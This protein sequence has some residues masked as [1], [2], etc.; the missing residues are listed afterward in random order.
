MPDP[1]FAAP[2]FDVVEV[3]L[4]IAVDELFEYAVPT[5]LARDAQPGRRALVPLGSRRV[6]GLIVSR[7]TLAPSAERARPL[8]PVARVLD[9][10]AVLSNALI[11]IL[12]EAAR[13]FL[14]PVGVALC[15]ALP[16]GSPRGS[17]RAWAP[18]A[19]GRQAL[20]RGA[21]RGA[22]ASLLAAL[23]Q[24]P[25]RDASIQRR[26][27]SWPPALRALARDGLVQAEALPPNVRPVEVR[28]IAVAPGVDAD[29]ARAGPLA[30][31]PRQAALLAR[32][33][34]AGEV[35]AASLNREFPGAAGLL[36]A[37]L[38]RALVVEGQRAPA[39]PGVALAGDARAAALTPEQRTALDAV[40]AAVRS[41]APERFLLHGVTGSGKTEVYLRAIAV[42]LAA[43]RQAL[44][45]VPEITLTH[46]IVARLRARFGDR[47]AILHSGLRQ[48]E[49][50]AQWQRL[51]RGATP[52]AVGARSALFAPLDDLGLI[53]V[54]EEHDPAYKSEEG[55][56]Y[57]AR[58][59]AAR[60]AARSPCPLLLGSATPSLETRFAA[61]RAEIERLVLPRRVTGR[62]LPAVEIVDLARE[63]AARTPG[64]KLILSQP[65]RRALAAALAESGQAILLLNRR[66]FSTRVFC[67]ECGHAERCEHCDVSLVFHA[68]ENRLRCHYCG[69][70]AAPPDACSGCGAPDTA[71]LGV[72][73]ERL[74]EEVRTAFPEARIARLDRDT[75]RRRGAAEAVLA[76]LASGALDIVV[77][78][79]MLAKGHD[80]P[81]VRLVGVVAADLGLHLPDFRAA[82]RTFQLLTQVAGRAGRGKLPGR[83][84]VQTFAPDH[85][86]I[87]PVRS[88]AYETF[89]AEE[90]RHRASL[91]YPP[92][93]SLLRVVV[94]SEDRATAEAEAARLAE[95]ARS[96]GAGVDVLAA[97]APIARL[98]D[99]FRFQILARSSDRKQLL[100]SGRRIL[101]ASAR[102]PRDVRASVDVD[103]ISML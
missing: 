81:G 95:A 84:I 80:F 86:A 46:Q 15:A 57:C 39:S 78:T 54:D 69:L 83:V 14:C 59:L 100:E 41:R 65:L 56:R 98:R 76:G 17:V 92:F 24:R 8:R 90:L 4:P 71:L 75:A 87:R 49:R 23:S 3:A 73:T 29:V 60:R 62:P 28:T 74:E 96:E 58:D 45:L 51:R 26:D 50:R 11:E 21:L 42:A 33:R 43:G 37:L 99:R 47:V 63:R 22:A 1:L 35:E 27:P 13:D 82:E 89:Y 5:S 31:A 94:S 64:R 16:A 25:L 34:D 48:G 44:V 102:L 101:D 61:D 19:K 30:H 32:L 20:A 38:R 70:A 52:I 91:L 6:T 40:A 9:A 2:Q 7:R 67:F 103:P 36:R 10:E 79:Q 97:P 93:G 85:Y 77:G 68:T 12:R 66:G 88:H 53:V 72:G 55:F 18:T